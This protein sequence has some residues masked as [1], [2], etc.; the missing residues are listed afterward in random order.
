MLAPHGITCAEILR[1]RLG[2]GRVERLGLEEDQ[3][4][5]GV[6][7]V[8]HRSLAYRLVVRRQEQHHRRLLGV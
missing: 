7:V 8:D 4:D 6:A 2:A 5:M 1:S 3:M